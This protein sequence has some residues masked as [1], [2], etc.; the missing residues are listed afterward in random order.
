MVLAPWYLRHV[1]PAGHAMYSDYS[2]V[3]CSLMTIGAPCSSIVI[4]SSNVEGLGQH[5]LNEAAGLG[6][7]QHQRAS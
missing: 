3:D 1:V 2:I 5:T 7:V 4:G 6:R